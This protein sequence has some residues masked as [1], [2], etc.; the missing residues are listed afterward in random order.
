MA[1]T[2]RKRTIVF[3]GLITR[4]SSQRLTSHIY[5]IFAYF[6]KKKTKGLTEVESD[7]Q[8]V[9]ILEHTS[10]SIKNK[11]WKQARSRLMKESRFTQNDWENTRQTSK[12]EE[13]NCWINVVHSW[14][15]YDKKSGTVTMSECSVQIS[16]IVLLCKWRF[17]CMYWNVRNLCH[18]SNSLRVSVSRE[19]LQV[20]R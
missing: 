18:V 10:D 15:V 4:M 2:I 19:F 5:R 1:D 11:K 3:Y 6:L 16:A 13:G 7:L 9:S 8:V 14:R 12:P 20:K 17:D